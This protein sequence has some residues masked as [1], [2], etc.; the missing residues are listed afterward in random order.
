MP[1]TLIL[2]LAFILASCGD[3]QDNMQ[4]P[5]DHNHIVSMCAPFG[6]AKKYKVSRYLETRSNTVVMYY[7]RCNNGLEI[8]DKI[9]EGR[10]QQ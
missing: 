6:G 2:L 10:T 4:Y 1:R 3:P 7:A 8:T 5:E 9:S